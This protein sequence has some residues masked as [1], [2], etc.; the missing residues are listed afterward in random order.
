MGPRKAWSFRQMLCNGLQEA[1]GPDLFSW[2]NSALQPFLITRKHKI[3][4][5]QVLPEADC[6]TRPRPAFLQP[7][8]AAPLAPTLQGLSSGQKRLPCWLGLLW[9][10]C[11][12]PPSPPILPLVRSRRSG[13]RFAAHPRHRS[14]TL[15]GNKPRRPCYSP[16]G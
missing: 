6:V 9:E 10:K 8:S 5:T 15:A 2:R 3:T 1:G 11:L 7:A 12:L 13:R 14:N 16:G 4:N